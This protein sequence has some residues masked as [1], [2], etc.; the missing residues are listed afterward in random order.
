MAQ[1][2]CDW[3][4]NCGGVVM[5][6]RRAIETCTFRPREQAFTTLINISG[7]LK[8][9]RK[10]VEVFETMRDMKGVRANTYT[11]SALISA[12]SSCGEWDKALEI[13]DEMK[14]QSAS[15]PGCRPNQVLCLL[16]T[17]CIKMSVVNLYSM[18]Q[19]RLGGVY[20]YTYMGKPEGE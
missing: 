3:N 1:G 9:W 18:L 8:E 20:M 7:R 19:G 6:V 10:A 4:C 13:F 14:V 12:C 16:F 2:G 15:D 11:F 17:L 5:Q